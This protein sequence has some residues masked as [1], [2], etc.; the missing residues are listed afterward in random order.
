MA[1]LHSLQ[2][3]EWLPSENYT[4]YQQMVWQNDRLTCLI[5]GKKFQKINSVSARVIMGF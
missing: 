4:R 3:L 5:L 1:S 2:I